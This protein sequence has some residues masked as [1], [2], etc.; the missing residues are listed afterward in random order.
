[1]TVSDRFNTFLWNI[2][3]SDAQASDGATKHGGVRDCLN[4]NYYG[5]T[6]TSGNSFLVGSWG[7]SSEVRPP[8]DIDVMFVL[9]DSVYARFQ[10]RPG[11]KQSQLLQE[12]KNVLS[13][14]YSSTTMRADGQVVMVGFTT[15]AVEVVPAFVLTTG[16]YW[17]C[18]TNGGGRYKTTDPRAEIA[19][20]SNSNAKTK[21]NTRDLIRMMKAW[22]SY[23]S[24]PIK[25]FW[26]ELLAIDFLSTWQ[27]SGNS[28]TYYDWMTRDFFRYLIG[29]AFSTVYAPGTWEAMSIG[30]AWKSRAETAYSR[31]V[32]A[33]E[34]ESGYPYLAGAEW[35]RIFGTDIPTG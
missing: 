32:K 10:Q 8:R 23:C 34:Y 5:Y 16:Q 25:S 15:Y 21:N 17:I 31:A 14:W 2:K 29:R 28:A 7:K 20:V 33:C 9:P 30:D 24:V 11:N 13:R 22:Q 18:D 3:L 12:V 4:Q 27:Y 35:Q 19:N 26:F 1:M 6:S